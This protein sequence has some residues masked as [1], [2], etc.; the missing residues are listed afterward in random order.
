MSRR[1]P[2]QAA[3][4][5]NDPMTEPPPTILIADDQPEVLDALELLVKSASYRTQTASSPAE[6]LAALEESDFDALLMD[7]NYTKD[8]TSGKEGLDLLARIRRIDS[9]F[10]VIVMTAYGSVEGAV[11]AMKRGARDYIQ[12]PWD[13]HRV[14]SILATQVELGRALKKSQRLEDEN[15][16]LRRD[17]VP[18]VVRES[19]SMKR[20]YE[21]VERIAPSGANVLV[22]GEH[23]TGK[24]V[25]A[26]T[27]HLLSDR[28]RAPLVVVNAGALSGALLD[29]ELFGH[30]KGA[31]TDAKG[32]R[33]GCFELAHRGTLFLDEIGNLPLDAQAKMLRVIETGELQRVGSSRLRR[34]DVRLV[35]ATNVVLPDEVEKG[36]F[37]ED[38]LYRLN[39]VEVHVPPLRKRREDIE[40]L[41]RLFLR[42]FA[43]RRGRPSITFGAGV[44]E[45]LRECPW[46]GNVRE[47][48]HVIERAVLLAEGETVE[49]DDLGLGS[50]TA[51]TAPLDDMT[52]EELERHFIARALER[53]DGNVVRAGEALGLSRSAMYR[54]IEQYGM[55]SAREHRR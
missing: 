3:L 34:V 19:D 31:F 28:A 16:L 49:V 32:D 2:R 38:L 33:L 4:K 40:P 5:Q 6:V 35:A 54:R 51:R 47:L 17:D 37:R 36:R 55:Q 45:R 22:T 42:W 50:A 20:V 8:T 48:N 52:L 18:E 10:P 29:S 25:V 14:L 15:R 23:G 13:N 46:P 21:L 7:L 43:T 30:V 41:A 44:L 26:R 27:L 39:T 11:E 9:T 12:K 24:E 53:H 1:R